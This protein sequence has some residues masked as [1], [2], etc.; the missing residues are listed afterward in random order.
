MDTKVPDPNAVSNNATFTYSNTTNTS[1]WTLN[2]LLINL[3]P[4]SFHSLYPSIIAMVTTPQRNSVPW[5][6]VRKCRCPSCVCLVFTHDA[7]GRT[8]C[9]FSAKFFRSFTGNLSGTEK[10]TKIDMFTQELTGLKASLRVEM[11]AC[12]GTGSD[13]WEHCLSTTGHKGV[14]CTPH[15]HLHIHLLARLWLIRSSSTLNLWAEPRPQVSSLQILRE[16]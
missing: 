16:R 4:S 8:G 15:I 3:Q 11:L 9:Y 2:P 10:R 13:T 7:L 6:S 14:T 12:G 5:K 1:V